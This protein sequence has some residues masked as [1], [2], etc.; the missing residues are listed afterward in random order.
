MKTR[1]RTRFTIRKVGIK[2]RL[3][4]PLFLSRVHCGFPSPATDYLENVLDLNELCIVHPDDTYFV[5]VEGNSMVNPNARLNSRIDDGDILVVDCLV[6]P[7][8][9][10][11]IVA[12]V[13]DGYV[14]RRM[15]RVGEMLLLKADNPGYEPIYMHPGDPGEDS[16]VFGTVTW[17][18]YK[19][20]VLT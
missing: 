19:P 15:K 13:N 10:Q 16:F 9:G 6:E 11:I 20:S 3:K 4:V 2:S 1:V 5:R 14:V 17:V 18:F 8:D 7:V 12:C